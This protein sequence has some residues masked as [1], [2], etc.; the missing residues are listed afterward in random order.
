VFSNLLP[1]SDSFVAIRC[2]GNV[3]SGPLLS[4]GR[5]AVSLILFEVEGKVVLVLN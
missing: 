5:L 3:I 4:N 1:G 2:S